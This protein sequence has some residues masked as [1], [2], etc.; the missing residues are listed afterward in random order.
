[1]E[2]DTV[3]L[4]LVSESVGPHTIGIR[5]EPQKTAVKIMNAQEN[6]YPLAYDE[7]YFVYTAEKDGYY[8]IK[9]SGGYSWL[10]YC[11]NI[12]TSGTI[13]NKNQMIKLNKDD[14]VFLRVKANSSSTLNLKISEAEF[15]QISA[16]EP[17]RPY[18]LEGREAAYYQ[19]IAPETGQYVVNL[20][21]NNYSVYVYPE[22]EN[23]SFDSDGFTGAKEFKL[24]KDERLLLKVDNLSNDNVEYTITA[25][26]IEYQPLSLEEQTE[27][28]SLEKGEVAYYQFTAEEAGVYTVKAIRESGYTGPNYYYVDENGDYT[29]WS[30]T[31]QFELQK[32]DSF[33]LKAIAEYYDVQYKLTVNK[34]EVMK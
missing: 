4:E 1:M 22:V 19:F 7:N 32:G 10:A 2:G 29:D 21:R 33:I 27:P 16:E 31:R 34:L 14:R 5:V 26:M 6:I 11:I 18:E 23:G 15:M 17:E 25:K 20:K 12:V 24:A 9:A 28:Y 30:D 3:E 8:M 13:I